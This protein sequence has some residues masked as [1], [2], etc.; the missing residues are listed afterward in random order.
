MKSLKKT[1]LALLLI[2]G[3]FSPKAR[4]TAILQLVN[5][6]DSSPII[7]LHPGDSF[8]VKILVSSLS[9]PLDHFDSFFDLSQAPANLTL[10]GFTSQLP[11]GWLDLPNAG[12]F[13]YGGVN[14]GGSYIT[15]GGNLF[16]ASFQLDALTAVGTSTLSFITTS[17][18]PSE[19]FLYDNN[20]NLIP[21][22]LQNL[23]IQVTAVP[24]PSTVALGAMALLVAGTAA[25]RRKKRLALA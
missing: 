9:A 25:R 14:F 12:N 17:G 11:S 21:Y 13:A 5:A 16:L 20:N 23:T 19:T 4:A 24:E 6:V 1:V 18:S 22:T 7:Q 3:L 10:T 15:G 8:T 2:G